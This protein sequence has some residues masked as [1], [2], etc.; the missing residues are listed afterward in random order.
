MCFHYI[1]CIV[2]TQVKCHTNASFR[3]CRKR[4]Q[5]TNSL[6]L[7]EFLRFSN[8]IFHV[9]WLNTVSIKS[10]Y[11]IMFFY[12]IHCFNSCKTKW[13]YRASF[14]KCRKRYQNIPSRLLIEFAWFSNEIFHVLLHKHRLQ[15]YGIK[16]CFS[17]SFHCFNSRQTAV[18][19]RPAKNVGN[20]A[21]ILRVG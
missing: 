13:C 17:I 20:D 9:I 18:I 3:I 6:L 7:I 16:L 8:K 4:F 12:F 11:Q 21:R 19:M 14:R 5:N 10:R 2:L 1:S 15:T